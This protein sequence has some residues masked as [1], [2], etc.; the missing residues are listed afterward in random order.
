VYSGLVPQSKFDPVAYSNLVVDFAKVVPDNVFA[1]AE[2]PCDFVIFESL[3]NQLDNSQL[4]T[5]RFPGSVS[6]YQQLLS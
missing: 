4:P 5:A 2:L 3:S 6:V 1:D